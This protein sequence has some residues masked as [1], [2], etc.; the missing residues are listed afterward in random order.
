[1][2]LPSGDPEPRSVFVDPS[3][4]RATRLRWLGRGLALLGLAYLVILGGSFARAP[5]APHLSLPGIGSITPPALKAAPPALGAQALSTPAPIVSAG[6]STNGPAPG[7]SPGNGS[8][9]GSRTGT[10]TTAGSSGGTGTATTAPP[11]AVTTTTAFVPPGQTRKSTTTTTTA[12][13]ST[14]TSTRGRPTTTTTTNVHRRGGIV[15]P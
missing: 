7:R 11:A 13:V 5:W 9:G 2:T 6:P 1:M 14:T 15:H 3:G 4:R 10:P 12:A 8:S